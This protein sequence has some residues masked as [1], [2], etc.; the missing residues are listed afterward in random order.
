ML[1]IGATHTKEMKEIRD[2]VGDMTFLVP[3][4]GTQGGDIAEA[5]KAG[6][7]SEGRGMIVHA[8]RSV[9]FSEDPS[10]AARQLKDSINDHR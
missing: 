2:T 1:V 3:G 10:V 7:N 6:I 9:I 8:A 5:V 4:I